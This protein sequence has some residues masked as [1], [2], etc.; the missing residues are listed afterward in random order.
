[1]EERANGTVVHNSLA[2]YSPI[3]EAGK[4]D[5]SD[6]CEMYERNKETM[7]LKK[8]ISLLNG[9][10][11][12]VGNMIGSGIFVSPKGVLI[13]SA[14]YG[15]SLIIWATGGIF[16]VFGALCYAELGTTITKSGASYAYILEAF[17][18]FIAFIRLWTSLLIVE[19]TSQAIIAITF[20]NY[21]VQPVFPSCEPPYV[22]CRLIAAAC[23]CLLTFINCAYVKWGTRVQDIFTYAKVIA[24]IVIIITGI[25]KLCQGHSGHFQNSFEGSSWDLG[26]ISL[27]LYSALF[28]YSGWD[29][30]N[31]VTEEIKNPERN[32]PLAI[33]VSMPIVTVI[34]ILTN[35]AYYTVL[36]I[37]AVLS[38]DAVAVTFADQ[39]FGI[40]SWTVPVAVAISCFGGLNAS[41]LASSRLFFVGSREG[42]LP[43]LL[44]MIHIG[45][46]TP[47]PAL[48]FNCTMALIYLTVEDVFQLINYFSF[49]YWF[50]VGLSI[51]GQLYLRWKEPDR[52]R[53]LKLSLFFPIAFCICSVFLVVVPLYSDTINSLIGIGIAIS[54]IPVYFIGVYLPI[55]RRPPFINNILGAITEATQVL[56]YSVLTEMDSEDKKL[57][58]KSN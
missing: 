26:D 3:K 36:D 48:L 43:D 55:S 35:I 10:S 57:E 18:S 34:Y 17:G 4:P 1:M 51:A 16:S 44:S 45:R 49:S 12:I 38:S 14:S 53:P 29:T 20:A 7:Q 47:V 32:L 21:I 6:S 19:P 15:L 5:S 2:E 31:F 27:A 24:L 8:E 9:I 50:F 22:A 58:T 46:F 42:H 54:G 41:I 39:V 33:A 56:C 30:L 11:L 28:S 25:V 52:P 40:F 37:H 13:Y 23:I